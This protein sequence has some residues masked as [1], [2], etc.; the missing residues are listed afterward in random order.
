MGLGTPSWPGQ[1]G[2][3]AASG[4]QT[5]ANADNPPKKGAGGEMGR[6]GWVGVLAPKSS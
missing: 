1:S 2:K 5:N 6:R 4:Q 3:C